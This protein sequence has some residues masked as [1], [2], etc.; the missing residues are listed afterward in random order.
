MQRSN[1]FL[2]IIKYTQNIRINP[3]NTARDAAEI[4]INVMQILPIKLIDSFL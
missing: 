3:K 2:I 1:F 4:V